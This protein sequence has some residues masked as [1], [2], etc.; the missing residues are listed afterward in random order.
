MRLCIIG[1]AGSPFV[2]NFSN[3]I[4]EI[5]ED[6]YVH[7][8]S[9]RQGSFSSKRI[10]QSIPRGEGTMITKIPKVRGVWRIY[11]LRQFLERSSGFDICHIHSVSWPISFQSTLLAKKSKHIVCSVWGSDFYKSSYWKRKLQERLYRIA[12][13]ITFANE[14]TLEEFDNYYKGKYSSKL[15]ICR[16]GLSPLDELK[17]IKKSKEECKRHFDIPQN[18]LVVVIGYN[19]NPA[20]QH[21]KIIESLEKIRDFLPLNLFLLLPMAYG[22]TDE[23]KETVKRKLATSG[24]SNKIYE[25]FM[26]DGEVAMLRMSSDLMIQV[27]VTD[28]LS[29]SMMEHLYAENVVI[30]GDWLPYQI[31]EE[32]QIFVVKVSS[33]E[34]VAAK[35]LYAIQNWEEL[36]WKCKANREIIW[37]FASWQK[38]IQPWIAMYEDLSKRASIS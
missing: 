25:K 9:T 16:F 27:Q 11:Q 26:M 6:S 33:V 20:Q 2:N 35:L 4:A 3:K 18:S 22:G 5:L 17:K 15:R 19:S 37:E 10:I 34:E 24:F 23:Y 36:R 28:Q 1:D 29:G 31:L 32:K 13:A 7:I 12:S 30:T 21:L 8:F 14:K 38:N